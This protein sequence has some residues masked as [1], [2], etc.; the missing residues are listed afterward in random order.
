[1]PG[2]FWDDR[3]RGEAYAYGTEPNRFFRAQ[4]GRIP[5]GG[6]LLFAAEGEGRNAVHAA[7]CGYE[8]SAFDTSREGQRKALA[9]AETRG[10]DLTY[11]VADARTVSYPPASFEGI[12]LIFA[13]MPAPFRRDVHRRLLHF[14]APGGIVI[15]EGFSR[16]HA[17]HQA[18]NPLAGGPLDADRLFTRKEIAEDFEA[19]ETVLLD[20][21]EDELA[22]GLYH[23]GAASLLR[24]IGIKPR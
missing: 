20:E 11:T 6:R 13:H 19:L 1:M 3:Y 2:P 12:V 23:Q 15:L 5:V 8:V 14:L 18:A 17:A 22:E 10:V 16:A 9:L 24:W 4:L 21:V 7:A